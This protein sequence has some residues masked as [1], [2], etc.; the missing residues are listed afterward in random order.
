MKSGSYRA[1][2][3]RG[4]A[5][6]QR[7]EPEGP[8]GPHIIEG[9]RRP[10][11]SSGAAGEPGEG[12][13]GQVLHHAPLRHHAR[14]LEGLVLQES[15]RAS[16]AVVGPSGGCGWAPIGP[17]SCSLVGRSCV[18]L[19]SFSKIKKSGAFYLCAIKK[20]YNYTQVIKK[21]DCTQMPLL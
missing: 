15:G 4:G 2:P 10:V 1:A 6:D 7:G 21:V 5:G 11:C 18:I 20:V 3:R 16:R 8:Q 17:W 19:T 12:A 14:V 13:G 9:A